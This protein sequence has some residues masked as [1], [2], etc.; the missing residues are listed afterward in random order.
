MRFAETLAKLMQERGE[1]QYRLAKEIGVSQAAVKN[2]LDGTTL[3]IKS[4]RALLDSH[5]GMEI[6]YQ[7]GDEN[8]TPTD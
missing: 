8:G 4:I 7:G 6:D 3:P 5:F 1:T 2:W